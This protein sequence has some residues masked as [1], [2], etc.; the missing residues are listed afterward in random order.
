MRVDKDYSDIA[1]LET[2]YTSLLLGNWLVGSRAYGLDLPESDSDYRGIF[3]LPS[4]LYL[5]KSPPLEQVAEE[6]NNR[7]WYALRRFCELA[8][9]SNPNFI[10]MLFMPDDCVVHAVPLLSRLLKVRDK[11]VSRMA[12]T[13]HVNYALAQRKRAR[14]KNK[15]VNN[16]QT[17][18][19]PEKEHFCWFFPRE[20]SDD[21]PYRPRPLAECDVALDFCR[22]ASLERTTNL[23]RLYRYD[24]LTGGIF[25]DGEIVCSSIPVDDENAR[26]VGLLLFQQVAYEKARADH[27]HYW[28]W[29]RNR[30]EARWLSQERGERDYDAKNMMH[31]LRL[32]LSAENILTVGRPLIRFSG[33]K[34]AFLMDVRAGKFS[35]DELNE[36]MDAKLE[37]LRS[38]CERSDLPE[39]PDENAVDETVLWITREWERENV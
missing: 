6:K 37:S 19:P 16:P 28:E 14:G 7:T 36:I 11:F 21:M 15:W 38:L 22:C 20:T 34:Q 1:V 32:L 26:C 23:Y 5:R 2:Q 8:S 25:Q 35:W 24:T 18:E 3:V 13:H 4:E 39:Y 33:E 10:E 17:S 30:N 12:Y 31:V 9:S 29:R 27:K